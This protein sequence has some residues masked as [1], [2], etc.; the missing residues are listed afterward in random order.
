VQLCV[1]AILEGIHVSTLN[2]ASAAPTS[3]ARADVDSQLTRSEVSALEREIGQLA[4]H[5]QAAT[6]RLLELLE[7]YDRQGAW[8]SGGFK[9]CAAW[10][11]WYASIELGAAREKVRVARALPRLPRTS[12]ALRCGELSYSKVRAMT[13]VATADNEEGLLVTARHGTTAHL[14]RVVRAYRKADV[15]AENERVMTRLAGRYL[16]TRYAEDGSLVVEGRLPPEEGAKLFS[17]LDAAADQLRDESPGSE[18]G[19]GAITHG[20]RRAD[21]LV[22]LA[23]GALAAGLPGRRAADTRR[24]V[25]H[26]DAEVLAD[27]TEDGRCELA[28]GHVSAE[29]ARRFAC[30]GQVVEVLDGEPRRVGHAEG[31]RAGG[32]SGS[33][34]GRARRVVSGALRRVVEA[35]QRRCQFPG[36]HHERFLEAHHCVHWADGGET[37]KGNTCLLCSYHHTFV[38]EGGYRV[39]RSADSSGF[40]FVSPWGSTLDRTPPLWSAGEHGARRLVEAQEQLQITHE[41]TG[42]WNGDRFDILWAVPA[43]VWRAALPKD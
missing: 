4:A 34:A 1:P 22:R 17:A 19:R 28:G 27:P 39:E 24:V 16:T 35:E 40:D 26:V 9:T 20:Q 2:E 7:R 21:A 43:S 42:R 38:H 8:A 6:F 10:L 13:R 25:V 29:S 5:I 36:C 31:E 15:A 23:D 37:S 41:T 11:S 14:E 32:A 3:E 12:D 18:T 30:D 33:R